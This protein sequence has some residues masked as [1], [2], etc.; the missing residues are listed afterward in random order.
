MARSQFIPNPAHRTSPSDRDVARTHDEIAAVFAERSE[1][2][3]VGNTTEAEYHTERL[4]SLICALGQRSEP[5]PASIRHGGVTLWFFGFRA[6]GDAQY[7]AAETLYRDYWWEQCCTEDAIEQ[8]RET[9]IDRLAREHAVEVR[10]GG[11][12]GGGFGHAE[13]LMG[14]LLSALTV[15]RLVTE[16]A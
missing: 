12:D 7:T 16:V 8:R 5:F 2:L 3:K 10:L 11:G 13:E 4:I 9:G 1:A 14:Y 15:P 6:N